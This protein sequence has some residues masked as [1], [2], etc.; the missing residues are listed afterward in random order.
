MTFT[1]RKNYKEWSVHSYAVSSSCL[2]IATYSANVHRKM[3]MRDDQYWILLCYL[4]SLICVARID[5]VHYELLFPDMRLR[6]LSIWKWNNSVLVMTEI[7]DKWSIPRIVGLRASAED[8]SD[9]WSRSGEISENDTTGTPSP[10]PCR[11]GWQVTLR[12]P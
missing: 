9:H 7:K 4:K 10:P 8:L 11:G 6:P 2:G 5:L 3:W 1:S 12:S